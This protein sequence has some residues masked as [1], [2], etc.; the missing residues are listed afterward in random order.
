MITTNRSISKLGGQS[1]GEMSPKLTGIP[2]NH[3]FTERVDGMT[4]KKFDSDRGGAT[5]R[6]F[7]SFLL[8]FCVFC[9]TIAVSASARPMLDLYMNK[10]E[11]RRLLGEFAFHENATIF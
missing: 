8:V 10:N 5:A 11:V 3:P 7:A 6:R 1:N 2:K 4:D 9:S